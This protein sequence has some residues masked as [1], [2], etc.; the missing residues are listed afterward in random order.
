MARLFGLNQSSVLPVQLLRNTPLRC[1]RLHVSERAQMCS[2]PVWE[3][4]N[5]LLLQVSEGFI[6]PLPMARNVSGT[7]GNRPCLM[8][9][10]PDEASFLFPLAL[11]GYTINPSLCKPCSECLQK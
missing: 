4:G 10:R 7:E 8:N 6:L 9:K 11:P 2:D 1:P 3:G 5:L